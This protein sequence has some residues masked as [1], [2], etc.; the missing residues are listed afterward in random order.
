M[1]ETQCWKYGLGVAETGPY[2]WENLIMRRGVT[3][4]ASAAFLKLYMPP[5]WCQMSNSAGITDIQ[6]QDMKLDSNKKTVLLGTNQ[7]ST[8]LKFFSG[9]QE[10]SPL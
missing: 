9:M 3:L 10:V 7:S 5:T 1:E 2:I 6:S 4:L 8:K